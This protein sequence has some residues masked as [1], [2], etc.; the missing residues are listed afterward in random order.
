MVKTTSPLYS[1]REHVS[2]RE[3]KDDKIIQTN[4]VNGGPAAV[5]TLKR[6]EDKILDKRVEDKKMEK[7]VED[8]KPEIWVQDKKLDKR[9]EDKK[10]EKGVEEIKLE[11]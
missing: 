8:K 9:V 10:L 2:V 6:V 5:I 3:L 7:Q 11:K 1:D 4:S